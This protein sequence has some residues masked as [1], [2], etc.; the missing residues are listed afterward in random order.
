VNED[1]ED[2]DEDIAQVLRNVW[3][4]LEKRTPL[5][6]DKILTNYPT[7]IPK[8]NKT[9]FD[10][11]YNLLFKIWGFGHPEVSSWLSYYSHSEWAGE[12]PIYPSSS[13]NADC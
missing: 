12:P 5:P 6:S 9:D 10:D 11:S 2:A 7:W 13:P 4:E 3:N 1:P 8:Y